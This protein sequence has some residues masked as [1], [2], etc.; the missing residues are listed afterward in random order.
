MDIVN[1][2]STQTTPVN[3]FQ[4]PV[5][6]NKKREDFIPQTF[7]WDDL[8]R[9]A[10]D[11][12]D[13]KQTERERGGEIKCCSP[14]HIMERVIDKAYAHGLQGHAGIEVIQRYPCVPNAELDRLSNDLHR[15]IQTDGISMELPEGFDLNEKPYYTDPNLSNIVRYCKEV[16]FEKLSRQLGR[17]KESRPMAFTADVYNYCRYVAIDWD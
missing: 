14:T 11:N 1:N 8:G 13:Y 2:I 5:T 7:S 17:L 10:C 4:T 15:K 9:I 16:L 6:A 12:H 3:N